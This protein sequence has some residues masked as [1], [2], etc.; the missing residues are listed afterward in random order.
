MRVHINVENVQSLWTALVVQTC[1]K[2]RWSR[3]PALQPFDKRRLHEQQK[4][5]ESASCFVKGCTSQ[6]GQLKLNNV[7]PNKCGKCLSQHSYIKQT[8]LSL[9]IKRAKG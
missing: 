5:R 6:E 8:M 3:T 9:N 1:A 4:E 2:V 7:T